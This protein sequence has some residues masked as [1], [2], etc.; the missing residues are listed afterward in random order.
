MAHK[1]VHTDR[2]KQSNLKKITK[3][4]TNCM[5]KCLGAHFLLLT[6]ATMPLLPKIKTYCLLFI[7]KTQKFEIRFIFLKKS[8]ILV[9]VDEC[10]VQFK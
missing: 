7:F 2:N 4:K 6:A 3:E 5:F 10:Q 9:N 1:H 8:K